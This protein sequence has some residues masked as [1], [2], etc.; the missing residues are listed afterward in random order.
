MSGADVSGADDASYCAQLVRDH[1]FERYAATLFVP[2]RARRPLLALYAFN[3][4]LRRIRDH[5]SQPLPGEIRLQWWRDLVDGDARGSVEANPVAAELMAAAANHDLPRNELSRLVDARVF[6]LYDDP[7]LSL[8]MLERYCDDTAGR[9]F[10]L[11][12]R[13]LGGKSDAVGHA[14]HH[15]GIAQG[16]VRAIQGL[17]LHAARKQLYLPQDVL[18]ESGAKEADLFAGRST[19]QLQ[20]AI[21]RLSDVARSH[22]GKAM[23]LLIAVPADAKRIFLPLALVRRAL[24]LARPAEDPFALVPVSRLRML[25]TL[26]RASKS[27]AFRS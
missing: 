20:A 23:D 10:S 14:A 5:V 8:D 11:S 4:E 2:P 6:D 3:T 13:I 17:P 12:A 21:T 18:N 19:P 22:L 27:E 15:T 26:W 16:I 1:D 7:M 25:W 9:L 24:D